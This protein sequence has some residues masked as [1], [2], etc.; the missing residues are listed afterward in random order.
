MLSKE[1][2][3]LVENWEAVEDIF[4]AEQKLREELTAFL[5]S[6]EPSL[7]KTAW[8]SADWHFNKSADEQVYIAHSRWRTKAGFVL[9]IGVQGFNA[10]VLFGKE[11]E[12]QLYLWVNGNGP[13]TEA[14]RTM[15]GEKK[16]FLPGE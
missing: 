14:L 11:S 7:R 9:W 1:T 5:S 4:A 2:T 3:L 10:R 12:P 8:W 6:L 15:V 16:V 13:L